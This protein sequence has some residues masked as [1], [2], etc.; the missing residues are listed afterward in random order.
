MTAWGLTYTNSDAS[1]RELRLLRVKSLRG[2]DPMT[3]QAIAAAAHVAATGAAA[4]TDGRGAP[5]LLN[6]TSDSLP[7]RVVVR[8]VSLLDGTDRI[9]FEGSPNQ[10]RSAWR[11]FGSSVVGPLTDGGSLRSGRDCLRCKALPV[12]DEL[13][14]DPGLLGLPTNGTHPRTLAP[15]GLSVWRGCPARYLYRELGLPRADTPTTP[16]RDRG[17]AV[18]DWLAAAHQRGAA[19]SPEDLPD[20]DTVAK[21]ADVGHVAR[22]AGVHV[23]RYKDAYPYLRQHISICPLAGGQVTEVWPERDIAVFDTDADVLVTCRP[24]LLFRTTVDAVWRETKSMAQLP[25]ATDEE[26]LVQFP[27]VALAVCLLADNA[28]GD[29]R[30]HHGP[31]QGALVDIEIL[32]LTGTRV[33]QFDAT[34]EETVAT[35]RAAMASGCHDWHRDDAFAANPGDRCGACEVARWCPDAGTSST[36]KAIIAVDGIRVDTRT[37]EVL[38]ES[39]TAQFRRR[40]KRPQPLAPSV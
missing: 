12:C 11:P 35:A 25:S 21:N 22:A 18:H 20:L 29:P 7:N 13:P 24:D 16:A 28:T 33:A 14:T 30:L 40:R 38:N 27:Q 31:N 8:E 9:V 23:E 32:G 26:L 10:A 17:I 34:N 5:Y 4:V 2:R 36:P 6:T 39:G 1:Q 37:G 19:C 15:T 3:T